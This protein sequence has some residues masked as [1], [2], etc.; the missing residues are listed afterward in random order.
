MIKKAGGLGAAHGNSFLFKIA[1]L[2]ITDSFKK[3]KQLPLFQQLKQQ[4][5]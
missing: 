4:M 1:H 5:C 2:M 3:L